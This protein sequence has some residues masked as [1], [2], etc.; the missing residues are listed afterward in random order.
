MTTED[1]KRFWS[2]VETRDPAE[3]WHWK[4]CCDSYQP[5]GGR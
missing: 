3:C 2:K 4:A 5:L 1:G